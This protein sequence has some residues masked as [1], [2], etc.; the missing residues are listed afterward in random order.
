MHL[1]YSEM[2]KNFTIFAILITLIASAQSQKNSLTGSWKVVSIETDGIY[3]EK[4]NDSIVVSERLKSLYK[5]G[6]GLQDAIAHVRSQYTHNR[7]VFG[8]SN[9]Y[10]FYL[11][12]NPGSL[13]FHGN[14]TADINK[15][16]ITA[17]VTNRSGTSLTKKMWYE[18]KST[19]LKLVLENGNGVRDTFYILEREDVK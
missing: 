15:K 8:K 9:T 19:R 2:K 5:T 3:I 11:T 12:E 6:V 16:L 13:I 7:F 14:Y 17:E 4:E 10:D 18:F 1:R